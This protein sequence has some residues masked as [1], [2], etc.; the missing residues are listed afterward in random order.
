M[1]QTRPL[2]E[3]ESHRT[4]NNDFLGES[5]GWPTNAHTKELEN[6]YNAAMRKLLTILAVVIIGASLLAL[7]VVATGHDTGSERRTYQQ[8][9]TLPT[10]RLR[11]Q[12]WRCVQRGTHHFHPHPH[13]RGRRRCRPNNGLP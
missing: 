7:P 3:I 11:R 13:W 5:K 12:C 10:P 4:L 2:L 8:C 6:G 9:T 1:F